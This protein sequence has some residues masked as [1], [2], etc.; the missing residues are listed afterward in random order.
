MDTATLPHPRSSPHDVL[1][2]ARTYND[3]E[4]LELL[5][6]RFRGRH[7][8]FAETIMDLME[9]AERHD[10]ARAYAFEAI[11]AIEPR[12]LEARLHGGRWFNHGVD[13]LY[14]RLGMFEEAIEICIDNGDFDKAIELVQDHL[15]S[16][17]QAIFY[18]SIY[19]AAE[20][21]GQYHRGIPTQIRVAKLLKDDELLM[22]TRKI[23][24]DYLLN[25]RKEGYDPKLFK[26]A[27]TPEQMEEAHR[28]HLRDCIGIYGRDHGD[29]RG[30]LI[31]ANPIMI[32]EA[33]EEAYRDL[34]SLRYARLAKRYFLIAN[35]TMGVQRFNG[36][37]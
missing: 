20:D 24:V 18:R 12:R 6:E 9:L 26:G 11:A 2:F 25:E 30:F 28:R 35:D 10:E 22:K 14:C 31:K 15:H 1:E 29:C 21:S 5:I 8:P 23:Y 32:A 13:N 16:K 19:R 27:A 36:L 37:P 4:T 34:G 3:P 17:E 33:A 7:S